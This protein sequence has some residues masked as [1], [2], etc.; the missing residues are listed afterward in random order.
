MHRDI[1]PENLLVCRPVDH[2]GELTPSLI[3]VTDF[4]ISL[5]VEH[6]KVRGAWG[7]VCVVRVCLCPRV[8]R[9]RSRQARVLLPALPCAS[10]CTP[11]HTHHQALEEL[12]GTLG[13]MAPELLQRRY[14]QQADVWSNGV[15]LY[16]MVTGRLPF[17]TGNTCE[18]VRCEGPAAGCWAAACSVCR[19]CGTPCTRCRRCRASHT[20][21]TPTHLWL[22]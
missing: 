6:G 1:K 4:G 11:P 14:D 19:G 9:A 13:Y 2:A 15:M 18:E 7:S 3:K 20:R 17:P 21:R 5:P 12:A 8:R 10:P 22:P 16:E